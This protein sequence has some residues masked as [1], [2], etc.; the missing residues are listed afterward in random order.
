M[1]IDVYNN[2]KS[3][4]PT[5]SWKSLA[6]M[7]NFLEENTNIRKKCEEIAKTGDK[8]LKDKLPAMMPMGTVGDKTRKKENCTPTGLVM[9]DI[10]GTTPLDVAILKESIEKMKSE[11]ER[12]YVRVLPSVESLKICM[13][14]GIPVNH[15][16]A[17]QGPF[18]QEM[19]VATLR[20]IEAGAV[21]TKETGK[22]GGFDAKLAAAKEVGIP[23]VVVRNPERESKN[24]DRL[25]FDQILERL[26][27]ITGV[28]TV[29]REGQS[30][31]KRCAGDEAQS[32]AEA[33]LSGREYVMAGLSEREYVMAGLSEREYVMAAAGPGDAGYLTDEVRTAVERADVV[34]GAQSIIEKARKTGPEKNYGSY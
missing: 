4:K 2:N 14:C 26:A 25:T 28:R 19:N 3:V 6:D 8:S 29:A 17:M 15:F 11:L 10:D 23:I 18:T 31:G 20:Q 16:V 24:T 27:K 12:L 7:Y 22:V 13:E 32:D 9:I 1:K 34:F 21:L 33:D 5:T 30:A